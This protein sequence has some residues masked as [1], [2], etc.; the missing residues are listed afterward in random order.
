M[1]DPGDDPPPPLSGRD[2]IRLMLP[3]FIISALV[4][5]VGLVLFTSHHQTV[6]LVLI[7]IG[8]VGGFA[9][10]A[11]IMFRQQIGRRPPR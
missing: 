4:A 9:I 1:P 7:A 6:G 10:R 8:A 5:I 3:V 11:R 2:A